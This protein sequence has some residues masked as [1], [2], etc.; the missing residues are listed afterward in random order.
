MSETRAKKRG[1]LARSLRGIGPV[2]LEDIAAA[3][4]T[5]SEGAKQD[6]E[7][8]RQWLKLH[9]EDE[10]SR[11]QLTYWQNYISAFKHLSA[12]FRQQV[13]RRGID[14]EE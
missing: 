5:M 6:A 14:R 7:K 11:R 3:I 8:I 2:Q 9:P 12:L 4:D 10:A 13:S 1:V